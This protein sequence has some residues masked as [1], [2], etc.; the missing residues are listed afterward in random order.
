M[1]DIIIERGYLGNNKIKRA[2]ELIEFTQEMREEIKR[3]ATDPVYFAENYVHIITVDRGK[4]KIKLYDFQKEIIETVLGRRYTIV[5]SSR[6]AG[7]ALSIDTPI[8][9]PNGWKL[10]GELEVGD[11]IFGG[12]GSVAKI[13]YRTDTMYDHDVYSITFDN[14]EVIKADA[15][16]IWT[17]ESNIIN[18]RKAIN[19]TTEKLIPIL[20]KARVQGQSVRIKGHNGVDYPIKSLPIDPY[21]L[22]I[23]LGDG[24]KN[25]GSIHTSSQDHQELVNNI[26]H[27]YRCGEFIRDERVSN[28]GRFTIYD[29][30][31]ILAKNNLLGNKHI[32]DEYKL[33]SIDQRVKLIRG[34]MDSDGSIDSKGR[35][36]FYQKDEK[37][38]DDVR[39]ILSSL[40]V[41][42]RKRVKEVKG[43]LY[44]TLSF[45]T[46]KHVL[47]SLIR[48]AENQ[49]K[50]KNHP[51]NDY[52]YI[53]SIEKIES[54]PVRCIQVDDP[55]HL[56]LCSKSFIPT[57]NTTVAV[58][59]LLHYVLFNEYKN[60]LLLSNKSASAR[61]ILKRIKIAFE[62]LPLW[63]QQGVKEWNKGSVELEN[64][65][66][67]FAGAT[68]NSGER[69]DTANFVYI[70]E[71]AF[72]E[73]WDEFYQSTY[74]VITSGKTSKLFFTSCVTEDTMVW[75]S[76][77]GLSE[78]KD[79]VVDNG[80][81]NPNIG[82]SVPRYN[83]MGHNKYN[84]GNVFVNSGMAEV[85]HVK[86]THTELKG[87][88]E[89]KVWSCKNGVYGWNKLKNLDVGDYIA[90]KAGD[91]EWIGDDDIKDFQYQGRE[92]K[93]V[94][95]LGNKISKDLAYL[96]GLYI[97]EGCGSIIKGR[98]NITISC[99]DNLKNEIKNIVGFDVCNYDDL[100][101]KIN[102]SY[103]VEL[104]EY[105]GFDFSHKAKNKNIP[106]RLTRMSKENI[107]NMLSGMF[108]GDGCAQLKIRNRVSYYSSS[109]ILVDQ[110]RMLLM[111][112]GILSKKSKHIT[113]K[114]AK[115][116]KECIS[117]RLEIDGIYANIFYEE[118]GFRIERKQ[119]RYRDDIVSK[120]TNGHN[121]IPFGYE[122]F[123]LDRRG[124]KKSAKHISKEAFMKQKGTVEGVCEE[125]LYWQKIKSKD[126]FFEKVYDFSLDHIEGDD[127]CHSVIYN[128]VLGHQTPNGLNHFYKFCDGAKKGTNGFKYIEVMWNEVPGRDEKWKEVTLSGINNDMQ[129]WRQEFC[130]VT[131]DSMVTIKDVETGE[132]EEITM[133][134]LF[135]RT[136]TKYTY[137]NIEHAEA[138]RAFESGVINEDQ[139]EKYAEYLY[140]NK[141][142]PRN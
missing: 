132:I 118:I 49:K 99:G 45:S 133:K 93:N 2:G 107:S 26:S 18:G 120:R 119:S 36:E 3:C 31:P 16:H 55:N 135:E 81:E 33:S 129:Q 88:N 29:L 121:I 131:G 138:V 22:G 105:I 50:C 139:I 15:E 102:S 111:K 35:C 74:P 92:S 58:V 110:V 13:T 127:W 101:T 91:D 94:M 78:I 130:C 14:G 112:F 4:E 128:G 141:L 38:I 137:T 37:F 10:M 83:V 73:N 63:L 27:H 34:L 42:V 114:T 106:Q 19:I 80:I 104:F 43:E 90:I 109:E 7:K 21:V 28:A 39:E 11:D 71:T 136:K 125:N 25:D 44:Y 54:E 86:T 140:R 77:K 47:A 75:D 123:K 122:N 60:V 66:I 9:T 142:N 134:E 115:V 124:V 20:E 72:I 48:K 56:F 69:G 41:K 46:T 67:L 5:N 24:N 6:Q 32:P 8:P 61:K 103:L 23:W 117:Y 126:I 64:G 98:K 53:H 57:H 51:K 52:Y 96:F 87:S 1:S 17:V 79:Y 84:S 40:G 116:N 12:D 95:N 59:I 89:H 70:D 76:E 100:H 62:N 97:A 113:P 68:S 65:C 82:Y 85:H 108:D 30:W